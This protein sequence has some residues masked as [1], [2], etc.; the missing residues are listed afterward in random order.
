MFCICLR[1]PFRHAFVL[2]CAVNITVQIRIFLRAVLQSFL[3]CQLPDLRICRRLPFCAVVVYITFRAQMFKSK[4]N[5]SAIPELSFRHS[6]VPVVLRKPQS[7]YREVLKIISEIT[8]RFPV[9]KR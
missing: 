8:L 6:P 1:K 5:L 4:R 3:K 7:R 9:C 2:L